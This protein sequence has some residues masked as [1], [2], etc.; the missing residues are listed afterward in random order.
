MSGAPVYG[1]AYTQDLAR[2]FHGELWSPIYIT[3]Y[4]ELTARNPTL[5]R[6]LQHRHNEA[7]YVSRNND[8]VSHMPSR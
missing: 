6:W 1:A 4:S 2:L 3:V 7:T 5:T 8:H